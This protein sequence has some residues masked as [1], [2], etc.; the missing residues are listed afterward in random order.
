MTSDPNERPRP[1]GRMPATDDFPT[2]PAIGEAVPDFT[3]TDQSGES[4]TLS[5]VL[6]GS[7]AMLVF[8]R[9]ARW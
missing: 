6:R 3:L 7:R 1:T 4:V 8:H 2:G 9:S 5:E